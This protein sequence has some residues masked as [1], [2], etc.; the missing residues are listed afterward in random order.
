M[1]KHQ[2][3]P[4]VADYVS[5]GASVTLTCTACDWMGFYSLERDV[6]S[7]LDTRGIDVTDKRLEDVAEHVVMDCPQC[8]AHAWA[9]APA[10]PA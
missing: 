9:V 7:R 8:G 10:I 6:V 4:S 1:S 2:S 3:G 5:L